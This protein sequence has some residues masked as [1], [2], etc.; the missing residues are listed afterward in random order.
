MFLLALL[1]F[2][3]PN[4]ILKEFKEFLS[5]PNIAA[6]SANI[7]RN[8]EWLVKAMQ[9]RGLEVKLLET[10]G[11]PPVVFGERKSPSAKRTFV[12][13]AHYDGQP[14]DER[15]W[16]TK[17]FEPV[18]DSERIWARG[19]SDDK[20]AIIAML[21]AL[22]RVRDQD[23]KERRKPD[24]LI[25]SVLSHRIR[26]G[27]RRTPGSFAMDRSISHGVNSYSS[28]FAVWRH[29]RSPSMVRIGNYIADITATGRRIP[30]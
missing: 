2:A 6:D 9:A 13:Y 5:I 11:A 25:W 4:E 19:A 27:S 1:L 18:V 30:Q 3:G 12:F 21:A 7:R 8:A 20:A 24:P 10:E 16:K 28:G 22:D 29:S 23:L 26:I 15:E 14:I 17:P